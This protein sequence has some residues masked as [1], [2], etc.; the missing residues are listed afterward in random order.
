M[1]GPFDIID[2][3]ISN[4]YMVPPSRKLIRGIPKLLKK[5]VLRRERSVGGVKFPGKRQS[6]KGRSFPAVGS[7]SKEC[8]YNR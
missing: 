7:T 3:N 8:N 1:D 4:V 5:T 2:S 6:F